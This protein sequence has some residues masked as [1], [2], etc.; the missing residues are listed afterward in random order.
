MTKKIT[1]HN[2]K[3][4][5]ELNFEIPNTGVH[6]LAGSNGAGK[7]SVLAC[8]RRIGYSNAF[9]HHF[10]SSQHSE[11]LDNFHGAKVKYTLNNNSVTYTYRGE[12]WAP[13]PRSNSRL[14]R[15]F[16]YPSVLYI[17]AT[18]ERITPRPED[19][20]PRNVRPAPPAIREIANRIFSTTK[21]N[22]L[23]TINLTRGAGNPAFVLQASPPPNAKY[24]SERNF[25]LGELCILKL[26]RA[27][28]TC[29]DRSLLLIDELE[30]A[31]HPKA[32][33]ELFDYLIE[34][35]HKKN[36]TVIFSTH[37][38][39]LLKRAPRQNIIFLE[40]TQG[41]IKTLKACFPTY[42]LG[43]I[44]YDEERAPDIV[45]YVEDE[46]A[47]HVTE[48]MARLCIATRFRDQ[49][50]LF[51][52]V[53]VV[54][55][56][57]FISVVRFLEHSDALLPPSTRSSSLLD[58]DVKEES[59]REWQAQR[60]HIMLA[61]F[62]RHG[63]RI[64]YLPWTPEVGLVEFI[65]NPNNRAEH[66][67]REHFGNNRLSIQFN[68]I[69]D[70]PPNPGGPQRHACKAAVSRIVDRLV[71][72]FPNEDDG[73]VR[74]GVFQTFAKWYFNTHRDAVMQ[75]MGPIVSGG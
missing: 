11:S 46:A 13:S 36:L 17:G 5:R 40:G 75:L 45:I 9:A 42:A 30:L 25:S 74:K 15:Q 1:I 32:Q 71:P 59:V 28:T 6:L 66:F 68:D 39:S 54:P 64:N 37:S 26:I 23:K 43:N 24:F 57:P 35:S 4:I 73:Y 69:G 58:L 70:I 55:I 8:L 49:A 27:L 31:L 41:K 20:N 50:S 7:T 16:G 10:A 18:A 67:F 60:N 44:A 53:H 3:H 63:N 34:I 21:F 52:T 22:S 61:E 65:R 14:L 12:R 33:V 62:Q 51:P 19:F 29:A 48:A 2:L 47:L 72:H 38:V 56:G